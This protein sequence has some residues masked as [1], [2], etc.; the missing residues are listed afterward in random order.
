MVGGDYTKPKEPFDN[1]AVTTDGGRT[2]KLAKGPLPHGYMSGVA[3]VPGTSERELV[4]VGL[5]GT[6]RS[7][8]GG[9]S[10]TMVDSVPYNS[11]A[12]ASRT[13]GWAAGPQ[14]RIAKWAATPASA[15]P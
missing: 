5:A 9:E 12:F 13:A 7:A 2:W 15:K 8:D 4:A 3:F 10:W 14:G 11:V 6:A 1:V